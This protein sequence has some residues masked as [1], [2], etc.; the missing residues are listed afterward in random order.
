MINKKVISLVLLMALVPFIMGPMC[1]SSDSMWRNMIVRDAQMELDI[2]Y[3]S[4][5]NDINALSGWV[6][7][8]A[9]FQFQLLQ[10]RQLW[11]E[12]NP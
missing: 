9:E 3:T 11:G 12:E 5:M 6:N 7:A 1:L 8:N 2:F 4:Q 10:V